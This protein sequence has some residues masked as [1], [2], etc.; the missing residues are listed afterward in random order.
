MKATRLNLYSLKLSF[1][2]KLYFLSTEINTYLLSNI[3]MNHYHGSKCYT[4]YITY[5]LIGEQTRI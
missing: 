3:G 1:E 2:N 5:H 4:E